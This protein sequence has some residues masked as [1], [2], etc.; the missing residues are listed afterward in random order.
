MAVSEPTTLRLETSVP[1]EK[2]FTRQPLDKLR[3]H[4]SCI[5]A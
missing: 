5:S 4:L 3:S 2:T 1:G